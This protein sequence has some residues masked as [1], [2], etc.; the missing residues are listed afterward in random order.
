MTRPAV[1]TALV[2]WLHALTAWA[3]LTDQY[4]ATYLTM[5][6][7]L[8]NNFVDDICQDSRGFVW[9]ATHGGGLVRYDGYGYAYYG[10]GHSARPLRSNSCRNLAE[11]DHGRLWV[12]FEEYTDVIDLRL[13]DS[14]RPECASAD[15]DSQLQ[16]LL[17]ERGVRVYN[18]GHH[19][20]WVVTNRHVHAL[21]FDGE[22]RVCGI[23][24]TRHTANTPD[25]AIEFVDGVGVWVGYGG[26]LH[27]FVL[28][29]GPLRGITALREQAPVARYPLPQN[30]FITDI[31]AHRGVVW[32]A[33]NAG[34]YRSAG[35]LKAYRPSA[36]P[37]SLSHIFV[38]SLAIAPD[39]RLMA[40]TLGGVDILDGDGFEHWNAATP[41]NPLGSN[42]VNCLYSRGGLVWVG[43]EAGGVTELSP[44]RLTL[45]NYVHDG[46][47]GSLSPNAVNAMHLEADG[48]LW[49]G[50]VEGGLN[51]MARG[52]R[53]FTHFTTANSRLSHNAVSTL[54][55]D[56][57]GTLWVGTW[58]G[59]LNVMDT[60]GGQG[61]RPLAMPASYAAVLRFVGALAYDSHNHALWIGSNDG[62]FY[63]DLATGRLS[64]PF[65]GCRDIRGCIGSLVDRDGTL[66][67]G[68]IDGMVRID[69]RR[70]RNGRFSA[71]WTTTKLDDPKSDIIDKITS[72]CQTRDGTIWLGSNVYG[73]YR[74]TVD[75]RGEHFKA[76]T[77]QDGLAS[78]GVKG[79]AEAP[80]GTLW[81]ATEHGLS[82]LDA[83]TGTFANYTEADG[84]ASAQFYWNGAL[85]GRD[86]WML[87]GSERGLT[88]VGPQAS[89]GVAAGRLTLTR[90]RLNNQDVAAGSPH[91][92]QDIAQA[93]VLR[94]HESDRSLDIDFALLGYMGRSQGTYSYRLKGYDDEW[95]LLQP[96]S[97]S[98]HYTALPS[99]RYVFEV[100]VVPTAGDG[101]PQVATI[102]VRVAP[103]FWKSWW[104][105]LTV[106]IAL[107][108]TLRWR[109]RRRM[110][111]MKRR[112]REQVL[113]PIA[114]ALNESDT[115]Q[116]LQRRIEAILGNQK[117]YQQSQAKSVEADISEVKKVQKPFVEHLMEVMEQNYANADFGVAELC[118]AMGMSRP[119][120]S[121]NM[122]AA[123]G[124]PTNQFIRN[125]RLDLARKLIL[126]DPAGRNITEIAFSV[127]FNDPKYFTRCFTKLYGT[128]PSAY[129]GE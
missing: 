57:R 47:P 15:L 122:N 104:F 37:A 5:Q 25:V 42:F 76:Y 98:A 82:R 11:D 112:E 23:A 7:G 128:S 36:D 85:A 32:L 116:L 96:G 126:Q 68:C 39:G 109:W 31:L 124:L 12:A 44:R 114:E 58:G 16:A 53:A 100:R 14:R 127:G 103:Y 46:R 79:I 108:L 95:T 111:A 43:T 101:M 2:L 13:M 72:F 123:I 33:T 21:S 83:K 51:R 121:K 118:A 90:V 75:V 41:V 4:N 89:K 55:S 17:G 65:P 8:P 70:R 29:D 6:D 61:P 115:P 73:L 22:G 1:L 117:K 125:Y 9:M 120:L 99:G 88:A 59:G 49:V 74:R 81:V 63:Y 71:R 62:I 69:L 27:R 64:D 113:R 87:F 93:R 52:S 102:E 40:G 35:T 91:L 19:H 86:G 84:L 18:D 80:D 20:L 105:V 60:K 24:S 129:K 78:N 67:M 10:I 119:V 48:T 3:T 30:V 54:A 77:V 34:L 97:H 110:E 28:P 50:T 92:E 107:A 106:A 38:S 45:V 26:T 94:L 66:W 56:G